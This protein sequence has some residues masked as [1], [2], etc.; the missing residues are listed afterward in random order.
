MIIILFYSLRNSEGTYSCTGV[1]FFDLLR[2]FDTRSIF[3]RMMPALFLLSL[4]STL[5][6][7][8]HVLGDGAP[9]VVAFHK[10]AAA[11]RVAA[12]FCAAHA[13]AAAHCALL[14]GRIRLR[15][16]V[17]HAAAILGQHRAQ[18]AADTR[19]HAERRAHELAR[20][21]LERKQAQD[22]APLPKPHPVPMITSNA[23]HRKRQ[24]QQAGG[25]TA[26][27]VD[28]RGGAGGLRR[29]LAVISGVHVG[30]QPAGG[31]EQRPAAGGKE[32]RRGWIEI[33]RGVAGS[34]ALVTQ[35]IMLG[36]QLA[37]RRKSMHDDRAG[38]ASL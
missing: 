3:F 28:G 18:E 5:K 9:S 27:G 38:F 31:S 1:N 13:I 23:F 29:G 4:G 21:Q 22:L 25:S 11:E 6:V 37:P 19:D 7:E 35:P 17:H 30:G 36:Q 12:A 32:S 8:H 2:E 10:N 20:A 15:Q 34:A 26:G 16:Q 14:E 33:E 24:L